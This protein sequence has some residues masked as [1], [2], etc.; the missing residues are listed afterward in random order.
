M[1]TARSSDAGVSRH[2]GS[3]ADAVRIPSGMDQVVRSG[4]P[5]LRPH[6]SRLDDF[7]GDVRQ[8]WRNESEALE[9]AGAKISDLVR[10]Q[11]WLINADDVATYVHVRN[12]FIFHKPTY[13]L[14]V[15]PRVIRS[16][17]RDEIE[18]VA[19]VAPGSAATGQD[20]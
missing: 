9:C 5:G 12:E 2:I 14:A 1:I 10:V 19:A 11:S 15:V 4:T 16:N 3:Y 6:G 13:M 20:A 18:V 17:V 8:A 7:A